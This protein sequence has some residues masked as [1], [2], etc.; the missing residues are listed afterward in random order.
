[1]DDTINTLEIPFEDVNEISR[2][3]VDR[4]RNSTA[5]SLLDDDN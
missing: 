4:D 1:M 5:L 2:R 3:L